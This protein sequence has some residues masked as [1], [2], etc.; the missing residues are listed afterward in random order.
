MADFSDRQLKFAYWW[1][2][3]RDGIQRIGT[4]VLM[5]AAIAIWAVSLFFWGRL[6]WFEFG[7]QRALRLASQPIVD[8]R[9]FAARNPIQELSVGQVSVVTMQAPGAERTL[10]EDRVVDV[11]NPN[12]EWVAHVEYQFAPDAPVAESVVLPNSQKLLIEFGGSRGEALVANPITH[13]RW[14]RVR[15]YTRRADERLRFRIHDETLGDTT[16]PRF[17]PVGTDGLLTSRV[18][19]VVTNES[20]VTF[21]RPAFIVALWNGNDLF[22]VN[23]VTIDPMRPQVTRTVDANWVDS[24]TMAMPSSLRIQIDPDVNILDP[25]EFL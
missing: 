8:I 5:G 1:L 23:R 7:T 24:F 10:R 11:E 18:E 17:L 4:R 20:A 2:T 16:S 9:G 13:V 6:I 19:F 22:A 25:G 15:D 12:A 14:E 3:H 21:A